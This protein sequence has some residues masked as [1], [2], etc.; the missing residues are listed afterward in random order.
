MINHY[1]EETLTT[2]LEATIKQQVEL[3]QRIKNIADQAIT[4]IK[5]LVK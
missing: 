3:E 4:D 5:N 1:M 2:L